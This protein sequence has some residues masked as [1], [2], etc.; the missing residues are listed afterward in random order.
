MS[1]SI[2]DPGSYVSREIIK[3]PR[4][5]DIQKLQRAWHKVA[6]TYEILR[7]R[8]IQTEELGFVQV[9]LEKVPFWCT[10]KSLKSYLSI[11]KERNIACGDSL[12][13]FGIVGNSKQ[14]DDLYLVW[15]I[16][17]ALYDAWSLD[18]MIEAV[19]RVYDGLELCPSPSFNCFIQH[20]VRSLNSDAAGK[21]WTFYLNE[22]AALPFPEK[23]SA[24]TSTHADRSMTRNILLPRRDDLELTF[25]TILHAAWGMVIASYTGLND[26]VF[27][28][29]LSGRT[30][31]ISNVDRIVGPL[32]TTVPVRIR[33]NNDETLEDILGRV[34]EEALA[35]VPFEHTGLQNI[36]QISAETKA[37]CG[38]QTIMV[39]QPESGR[40]VSCFRFLVLGSLLI[41]T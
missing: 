10:A 23:S 33:F 14:Q 35:M 4:D 2:R 21:F 15:T 13:H 30:I 12:I 9:V 19:E 7:T 38:F 6:Q 41:V 28:V 32:I 5:I 17:H 40:H 11:D 37:A 39:I 8:I 29:T 34:Q 3:L 26:A 16:H 18:L 24:S 25:S 20:K 1:L 27:G 36:Q 22:P 31:D